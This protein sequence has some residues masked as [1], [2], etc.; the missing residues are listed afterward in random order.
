MSHHL[1]SWNCTKR[2]Q[3][4]WEQNH[5]R[6]TSFGQKDNILN[7]EKKVVTGPRQNSY[8]KENNY[9]CGLEKSTHTEK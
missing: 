5:I 6:N 8:T 1:L 7:F 3:R 9:T 4:K 2:P